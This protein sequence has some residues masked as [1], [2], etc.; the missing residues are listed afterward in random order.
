MNQGLRLETAGQASRA[1]ER[2]EE[3]VRFGERAREIARN[4]KSDHTVVIAQ[5]T[6]ANMLL[7]LKQPTEAVMHAKR[8][9]ALSEQLYRRDPHNQNWR[10]AYELSLSSAGIV[11]RALAKSD[12]SQ[13]P[14]AVRWLE[15]AHSL[16]FDTVREDP[17][18]VRAKDDLVVQ[19]HRLAN[20]LIES[21]NLQAAATLYEHAANM[22]RQVVA[23][24]PQNRRY[25]YLWAANQ[26]NFGGLR[27]QQGLTKN[28]NDLLLSAD[29]PFQR[30][31][32][33]DPFDAA[34]LELRASQ[35]EMLAMVAEKLGD[36][37][38]ARLRVRQS[39]EVLCTMIVRD[40]SAKD[41]VSDYK[42]IISRAHHLGLSTHNLPDP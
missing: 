40:P 23:I 34:L 30:A 41:Y 42:Q 35:Y 13:L 19:S 25:W 37:E 15:H 28:A 1:R 12:P 11:C 7:N 24:N 36:R 6:L 22:A 20:A 10:R 2:M 27:L 21:G 32:A 8:A 39:L 33:L 9:V 16:A 4:Q 31:L 26:V 29:L 18:N 14:V 17:Q 38:T 3:S 5:Y